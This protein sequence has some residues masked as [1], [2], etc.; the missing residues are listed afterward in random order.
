MQSTLLNTKADM[1]WLR[2]VHLPRL[3]KRFKAAVI[4]GNEDWPNAVELYT[5]R[6]PTV[7]DTPVTLYHMHNDTWKVGRMHRRFDNRFD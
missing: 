2:D 4:Y 1:Q 3:S 5:K 6:N 7:H